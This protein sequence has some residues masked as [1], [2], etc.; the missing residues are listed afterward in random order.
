M[1]LSDTQKQVQINASSP[2]QSVRAWSLY[3]VIAARSA[4]HTNSAQARRSAGKFGSGSMRAI[5]GDRAMI[6]ASPVDMFLMRSVRKDAAAIRM[7]QPA[8]LNLASAINCDSLTASEICTE[9]PHSN[10][11]ARPTPL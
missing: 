10:D 9:A 8:A 11:A 7:L 5:V 3:C 6:A 4:S 2:S 1:V